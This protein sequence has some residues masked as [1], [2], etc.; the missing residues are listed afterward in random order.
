[1]TDPLSLL[2]RVKRYL[3][4]LITPR[5]PPV[6]PR[7]IQVRPAGAA[8]APRIAQSF[9]ESADP[10]Y[11]NAMAAQARG[12]LS[13]YVALLGQEP[14]GLAYVAWHGHRDAQVRQRAPGVPEI[15]KVQVL[16]NQRSRGIG[17]LLFDQIEQ[18]MRTRGIAVSG[19]GVHAHNR[20]AK[21]L[22]ERLGYLADAQP[23]FD[24]FDEID[25]HGNMQ[26]HRIEA[27]FMSKQLHA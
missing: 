5:Q 8:D 20:R 10:Q 13:L 2:R 26:H 25:A 17:A 1:M 23:Y 18:D 21:A 7:Q 11:T 14:A 19:L 4:A 9:P 3:Q 12:E 16:P 15:Y 24:E 22:Y 6:D 27:I